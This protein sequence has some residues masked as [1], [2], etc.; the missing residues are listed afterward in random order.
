MRL[1]KLLR[2][3]GLILLPASSLLFAQDPVREAGWF[4][5]QRQINAPAE[6]TQWYVFPEQQVAITSKEIILYQEG[7][8]QTIPLTPQYLKTVFSRDGQ[9]AAHITLNPRESVKAVDRELTLS[10]FS[11]SNPSREL[12]HINR[13]VYFDRVIPSISLNEK[14]GSVILGESDTGQLWFYDN[15]GN[16]ITQVTLFPNAEYDLEKILDVDVNEDGSRVAVVA[17]KRGGSPAGSDAVSPSAEPH[18]FYFTGDGQ[19][20][21]RRALPDFNSNEVAISPDGQLI[22]ANSFTIFI[23]SRLIKKTLIFNSQGVNIFTTDILFKHSRFS[24]DSRYVLLAENNQLQL[25]DAEQEK[26]LWK[27][28]I[29]LQDGIFIDGAISNQNRIT[30]VLT[31]KTYWENDQF[32]TLNPQVILFDLRGQLLQR[33]NYTGQKTLKPALCFQRETE[34]LIVGVGDSYRIYQKK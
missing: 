33:I 27:Q 17:G 31:A 7:G 11:I 12:Y 20:I 1:Q 24:F 34:S 25:V 9:F 26:L 19:E 10:I 23:N 4:K 28:K 18:L 32:I 14:N 3:F 5:F 13:K 29:S 21:W 8:F 6:L 15:S 22:M 2:I 16:L 30:A